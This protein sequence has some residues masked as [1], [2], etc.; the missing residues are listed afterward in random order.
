MVLTPDRLEKKYAELNSK[1]ASATISALE[2]I[3]DRFLAGSKWELK[4]TTESSF[5]DFE[6]NKLLACNNSDYKQIIDLLKKKYEEAGWKVEYSVREVPWQSG[7]V[8]RIP[9]IVFKRE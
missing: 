2:K 3:I 5:F 9:C 6:S 7:Q 4:V 8:D 1:P